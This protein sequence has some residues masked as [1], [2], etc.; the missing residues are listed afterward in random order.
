MDLV[1]I[2]S[3]RSFPAASH[4]PA[5]PRPPTAKQRFEQYREAMR[6]GN[7]AMVSFDFKAAKEQFEKASRFIHL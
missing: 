6:A 4:A 7:A 3:K 5:S 2:L 1:S